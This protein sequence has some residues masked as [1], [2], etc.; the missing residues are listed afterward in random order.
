MLLLTAGVILWSVA[1]FFKRIAPDLRASLGMA[2]KAIVAVLVLL[3]LWM[4]VSGYG[5]AEN[6]YFWYRSSALAGIN[7]LLMLF[8][9]YLYL[10]SFIKVK[11]RQ[12]VQHPQLA[13]VK[14]WAVA[15]LIVNGDVA[16][17]VLFGGLLAWAVASL[18][19]IKRQS[20]DPQSGPIALSIPKE[21]LAIVATL[22]V[23]AGIG[24]LH[25]KLGYPVFG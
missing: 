23:Y 6:T 4:M 15:H 7:N 22:V 9:V 10:T 8:A 12:W 16:S 20:P 14:L 24:L 1:H 11:V 21:I 18:I 13:A 5:T 25:T 2:G 19:L 3:A 17:F